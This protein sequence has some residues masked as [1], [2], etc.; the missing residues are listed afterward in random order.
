[1]NIYLLKEKIDSVD[2]KI[3]LQPNINIEEVI[4]NN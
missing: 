1:M 2:F 3:N 4:K